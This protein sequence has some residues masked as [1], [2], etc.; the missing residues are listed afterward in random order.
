MEAI[1][2]PRDA[3]QG[4]LG[5][6]V[7]EVRACSIAGC[8]RKSGVPGQ[9]PIKG[10]NGRFHQPEP[11]G[12]RW[13]SPPVESEDTTRSICLTTVESHRPRPV[14]ARVCRGQ[15]QGKSHLWRRSTTSAPTAPRPGLAS[16]SGPTGC[17]RPDIAA[18]TPAGRWLRDDREL[19]LQRYKYIEESLKTASRRAF[20]GACGRAKARRSGRGPATSSWGDV[21][22]Q[23]DSLILESFRP[24]FEG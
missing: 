5:P 24:G 4:K 8:G 13:R 7:G 19:Q 10:H 6:T 16:T 9:T 17:R 15:G 22:P 23:A 21:P 1:P 18:L 3:G 2:C 20:A 12:G 11:T 14:P